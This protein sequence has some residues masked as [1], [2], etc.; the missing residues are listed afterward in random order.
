MPERLVERDVRA[1]REQARQHGGER[2][3]EGEPPFAADR[4]EAGEGEERCEPA[5]E[6]VLLD[7]RSDPPR[8]EVGELG[9]VVTHLRE[10][11]AAARHR[12]R[13]DDLLDG[14]GHE[15]RG[16]SSGAR[17]P[18]A[19]AWHPRPRI[20]ECED[21]GTDREVDLAGEGDRGQRERGPD[22]P[23]PLE[24]EQHR[25]QEE[26]DQPQEVSGRLA[27]PIRREREDEP[28]GKR[29]CPDEPE[30]PEPPAGNPSRGDE[31]EQDDQVVGP[32]VPE[33]A[34]ERP[35]RDP[36]EPPLQVGRRRGL[37]PEGVGIGPGRGAALELV[38]RKPEGPAEL[39]VIAGRRLAVARR[40]A[41]EVVAV[42]VPHRGPRG[43]DRAG[44]VER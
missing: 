5:D 31:G 23:A 44:G 8:D 6:D 1:E 34:P 39:E 29:G 7:A 13:D 4:P 41:R 2:E 27:D 26:G 37:R 38:A 17:L 22:E 19:G 15:S 21:D 33:Q 42:D 11:A 40:W 30:G 25:R 20:P 16:R 36:E 12:A 43:P 9:R 32:D 24:R 28:A 35:E 14:D 18:P 10:R 3:E